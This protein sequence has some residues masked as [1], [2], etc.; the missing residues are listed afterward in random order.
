MRDVL[1][2]VLRDGQ[3]DNPKLFLM[4]QNFANE[5]KLGSL[6]KCV[7]LWC[8]VEQEEKNGDAPEPHVIGLLAMETRA[9]ITT[10]HV[11]DESCRPM[12]IKRAYSTLSDLGLIGNYILLFVDPVVEDFIQKRYLEKLGAIPAHRWVVPLVSKVPV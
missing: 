10:C 6:A 1:Q 11:S 8:V 7:R 12:L 9:D 2:V 5:Q 3:P 4:A